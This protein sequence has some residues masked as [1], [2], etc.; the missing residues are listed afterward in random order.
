MG[1]ADHRFANNLFVRACPLCG[2]KRPL[3]YFGPE[4]KKNIF[5]KKTGRLVRVIRYRKY[6]ACWK[7]REFFGFT[8]IY[9]PV[10]D[11]NQY[12]EEEM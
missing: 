10:Q 12:T 1:Q 8:A 4:L 7:C 5:S 9:D 11:E 6:I 3:D 2:Q